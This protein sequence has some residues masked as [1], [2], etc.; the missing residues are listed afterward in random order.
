MP[1]AS[2]LGCIAGAVLLMQQVL[3]RFTRAHA[4]EPSVSGSGPEGRAHRKPRATPGAGGSPG[5]HRDVDDAPVLRTRAWAETGRSGPRI[6]LFAATGKKAP[7]VPVPKSAPTHVDPLR[8][9]TLRPPPD[10]SAAGGAVVYWMVRDQRVYDNWALLHAQQEAVRRGAPLLV[11]V[12]LCARAAPNTLR[13]YRF[14]LRGW[15]EVARD[16]QELGIP[17]H[18]LCDTPAA[19]IPQL[20]GAQRAGLLVTDYSPAREDVRWREEVLASLPAACALDM[21]DAH[22]VVPVWVASEKQEYAARTIRK[23]LW[24]HSER[25]LTDFSQLQL[26]PHPPA[27]MPEFPPI[28]ELASTIAGLDQSVPSPKWARPGEKAAAARLRRF[29]QHTLPRYGARNDPNACALSDLSPW[30]NF[31]HISAQRVLLQALPLRSRHPEE[32]DAFVEE[33]FI[34]RE[35]SDNF[36]HYNPRYDELAGAAEWAQE[37]LQTHASDPREFVYTQYELEAARTH[38]ELWNAAQKQMMIRGKM[39]GY[40]R[41]YWAKKILEWTPSPAEALRLAIHLND[42]YSLDGHSPNGWV[43]CMWSICGLHDQG[44]KERAV[45]GKIRYMNYSGCKRKF[46]I[47]EFVGQVEDLQ[48]S[49][50]VGQAELEAMARASVDGGGMPAAKRRRTR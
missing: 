1:L 27:E 25:F 6:A 14:L 7:A 45:F 38:D 12:T 42:R 36:C 28:R 31:G 19:A 10:G 21:V 46:K 35:L 49:S 2:S 34:R 3:V 4:A 9:Q 41:M 16:L 22:N 30:L 37:T 8:I 17:F 29:L 24:A 44:W 13:W 15:Q 18:V 23:K 26:H 32:V 11:A 40:L 20:V 5:G 47:P 33:L 43:G 48:R 50:G 39:H